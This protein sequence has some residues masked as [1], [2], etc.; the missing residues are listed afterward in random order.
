MEFSPYGETRFSRW[1]IRQCGTFNRA[2]GT[3]TNPLPQIN[4][5]QATKIEAFAQPGTTPWTR[6]GP[7]IYSTRARKQRKA[8]S[9]LKEYLP[10]YEWQVTEQKRRSS[11]WHQYRPKLSPRL[12]LATKHQNHSN[13]PA[14]VGGTPLL[15]DYLQSHGHASRNR[16]TAFLH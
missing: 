15:G 10:P 13:L 3:E 14:V 16:H 6:P 7:A 9:W 11:D 1:S 12:V 5:N 2:P 4:R 8:R